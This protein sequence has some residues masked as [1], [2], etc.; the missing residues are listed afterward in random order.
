MSQII[1]EAI[2][3]IVKSPYA[4]LITVDENKRPS[5][6]YIGPVVNNGLDIYFLTRKDSIKTEHIKSSPFVSLVFQSP[7]QTIKTFRCVTI[8]GTAE[9]LQ[10]GNEFDDAWEKMGKMSPGY[11]EYVGKEGFKIWAMYK[12]TGDSVQLVDLSKSTRTI[13]EKIQG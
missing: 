8:N 3:Y 12:V 9:Y 11:K 13:T 5:S 4:L 2:N 1:D 7:E 10:Q 6:R